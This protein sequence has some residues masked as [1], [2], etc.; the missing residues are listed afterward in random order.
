ML[1]KFWLKTPKSILNKFTKLQIA[2]P[3]RLG[4]RIEKL[5][6]TESDPRKE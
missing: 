1:L 2:T 6:E 4:A 3:D 5:R